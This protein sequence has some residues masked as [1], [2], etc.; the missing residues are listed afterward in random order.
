MRVDDWRFSVRSMRGREKEI[1]VVRVIPTARR[2]VQICFCLCQTMFLSMCMKLGSCQP[3]HMLLECWRAG[4]L[5][6]ANDTT[7]TRPNLCFSVILFF[8]SLKC[9]FITVSHHSSAT[10]VPSCVTDTS[11]ERASSSSSPSAALFSPSFSSQL[12]I[13]TFFFHGHTKSIQRSSRS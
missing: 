5:L 12:L 11:H 7:T 8:A 9:P 1:V 13:S 4:G 2:S 10:V 3:Y 6:L